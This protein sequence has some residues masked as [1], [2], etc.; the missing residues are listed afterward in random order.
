M[1]P[2]GIALAF[3]VFWLII[4]LGAFLFFNTLSAFFK[5]MRAGV[6]LGL[7]PT[8]KLRSSL[9]ILL[10]LTLLFLGMAVMLAGLYANYVVIYR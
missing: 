7:L 8:V 10:D 1:N 9:A 5:N 6:V 2:L 4:G 3:V